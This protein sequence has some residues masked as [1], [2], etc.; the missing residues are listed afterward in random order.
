VARLYFVS[1]GPHLVWPVQCFRVGFHLSWPCQLF[2]ATQIQYSLPSSF[3][4]MPGQVP[5]D[6]EDLGT[7]DP[8]AL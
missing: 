3:V 8:Q 6:D 4:K 1:A 2:R 5:E 7:A